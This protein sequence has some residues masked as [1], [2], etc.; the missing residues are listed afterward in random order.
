MKT[1]NRI[2]TKHTL[3]AIG[4][5][6]QDVGKVAGALSVVAPELGLPLMAAAAGVGTATTMALDAKSSVAAAK[7]GD[8]ERS[9]S[10]AKSVKAGAISY[11]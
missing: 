5:A 11:R 7:R 9:V 6:A 8:L 10:K 1:M 2:G 3:S 4:H